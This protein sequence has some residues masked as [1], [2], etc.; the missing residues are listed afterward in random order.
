MEAR[1]SKLAFW[2]AAPASRCL[3]EDV[4][5]G[6]QPH[7]GRLAASRGLA[8]GVDFSPASSSSFMRQLRSTTREL[9]GSAPVR[10][11]IP[12]SP[13]RGGISCNA[14]AEFHESSPSDAW[15]DGETQGESRVGVSC[16]HGV[17]MPGLGPPVPE[18]RPRYHGSREARPVAPGSIRGCT[19]AEGRRRAEWGRATPARGR[20]PAQAL[21]AL[22]KVMVVNER[23]CCASPVSTDPLNWKV[24]WPS[25]KIGIC[26][27]VFC[28][29]ALEI[30][31]QSTHHDLPPPGP[32]V[33]AFFTAIPWSGVGH[34]SIAPVTPFSGNASHLLLVIPNPAWRNSCSQS[35]TFA[36]GPNVLTRY[37]ELECHESRCTPFVLSWGVLASS[38][39]PK[40]H[41]LHRGTRELFPLPSAG[42]AVVVPI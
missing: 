9:A 5:R 27:S 1:P 16:V 11:R 32:I 19:G 3:L 15:R 12:P 4:F 35:E 21:P 17:G 37:P 40:T 23:A 13:H 10:P 31:G 2:S 24:I 6:H 8:D 38:V 25:P 18:T 42:N 36:P 29:E 22:L 26:W 33:A 28:L 41:G 20:V 14:A 7:I 39:N 34:A 30:S